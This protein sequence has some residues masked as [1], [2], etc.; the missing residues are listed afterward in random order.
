M[1]L[2]LFSFI[3]FFFAYRNNRQ[4]TA[5]YFT[6]LLLTARCCQRQGHRLPLLMHLFAMKF[7]DLTDSAHRHFNSIMLRQFF[8]DLPK[9]MV[10]TK[11][12]HYPLQRH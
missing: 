4:H 2:F 10:G 12:G 7:G 3:A 8:R 1:Q 9:R 6:D 5:I 11:V